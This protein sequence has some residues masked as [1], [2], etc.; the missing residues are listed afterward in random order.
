MKKKLL[1]VIMGLFLSTAVFADHADSLALGG[2]F[3]TGVGI[4]GLIPS[5][6]FYPVN[7]SL[8]VPKVPVMWGLN[9][10]FINGFEFGVTGDYY[11]YEPNLVSETKTND[12]GNYE[13]KIDW[14]LGIGGYANMS[15]GAGGY[16]G[17]NGGV[18]IPFG[19][20]WH[21]MQQIKQLEVSVGSVAGI[22]GIGGNNNSDKPYYHWFFIPLEIAV[23]WWFD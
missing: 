21:A 9:L 17:G 14:Y 12:D 13:L 10:R 11:F 5:F 7:L 15:A 2:V 23:R 8:H 3:G 18:R 20:S 1:V 19:V 16:F 22:L 6:A 4:N